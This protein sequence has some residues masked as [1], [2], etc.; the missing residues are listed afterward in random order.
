MR[1]VTVA[2][3]VSFHLLIFHTTFSAAEE[4]AKPQEV[5][6][7]V[8]EAAKFLSTAGEEGV[9]EFA[10]KNGRWGWKD[11]YVW[12][13]KCDEMTNAA[14]PINPKLVGKNLAAM[15]DVRGNYLFVQL[16]EAAKNPQ[17]GWI[18]YW[19]PKVGERTPSRKITFVLPVEGTPY[20]VAAG[21]YDDDISLQ[22]LSHMI[23]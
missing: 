4:K 1:A 20:Q 11:T 8:R 6:A 7:K 23:R 18:E 2:V 5:V 9:A 17:G 10:D 3:L 19:W 13:L 16:C 21:I 15:K 22:E 14:H 12:V